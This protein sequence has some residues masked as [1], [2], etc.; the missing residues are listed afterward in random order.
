MTSILC[1]CKRCDIYAGIHCAALRV[2]AA[3]N[4]GERLPAALP[5]ENGCG[6]SGALVK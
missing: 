3:T 5:P 2:L 1:I 6:E 4:T